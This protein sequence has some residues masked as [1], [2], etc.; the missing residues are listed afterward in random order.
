LVVRLILWRDDGY[1][2][3]A[4]P[5]IGA[6]PPTTLHNPNPAWQ[7][8]LAAMQ[9]V[10]EHIYARCNSLT[11]FTWDS[12]PVRRTAPRVGAKPTIKNKRK[13]NR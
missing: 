11:A 12:R 13:R 8:T 5:L 3:A 10:P 6:L 1:M 2:I 4:A 7:E 9:I